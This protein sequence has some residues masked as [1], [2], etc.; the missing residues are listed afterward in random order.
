MSWLI[1]EEATPLPYEL[2]VFLSGTEIIVPSHWPVEVGNVLRTHMRSG[3]L[4]H[5]DLNAILDRLDLLGII[6]EP[7]IPVDDIGPLA[8]FAFIH[9][10]T[11]YD[12]VYVQMAFH[13]QVVLAKLDRAMRDAAG[14]LNIALLPA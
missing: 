4:S 2:P 7:P 13:R 12:A 5:E 10:L 3:R 11:A 14:K 9:N 6:A 1:G 8:N